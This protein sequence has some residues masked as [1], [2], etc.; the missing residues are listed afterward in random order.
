MSDSNDHAIVN[1]VHAVPSNIFRP[2][3]PSSELQ[4]HLLWDLDSI[5]IRPTDDVYV[6]TVDNI[7][8]TGDRYSV[9]LPWKVGHKP[10][11]SNYGISLSRLKGQLAKLRTEPEILSECDNI[12]K[13]QEQK[14]IIE[15]VLDLDQSK[16]LTH[17]LPHRPVVRTDAETTKVRIVYDASCKDKSFGVSL[18]DCL[19][20]GPS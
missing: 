19:H 1:H 4:M 2:Q 8:F 16:G 7:E 13:E 6:D 10:L 18:N 3:E 20:V 14:G 17:Y 15:Q 12:I 9:R 5:G 11:A